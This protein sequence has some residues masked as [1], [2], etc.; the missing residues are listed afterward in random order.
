MGSRKKG[1]SKN[2]WFWICFFSGI[3]GLI[4]IA[5][6]PINSIK[7]CFNKPIYVS[8]NKEE[9]KP[10][11]EKCPHCGGYYDFAFRKCPHCGKEREISGVSHI[12]RED[13]IESYN[14]KCVKCNRILPID[15]NIKDSKQYVC[16]YCKNKITEKNVLFSE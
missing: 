4:A 9:V 16:P 1:Y 6:A 7:E 11:E 13:K 3:I 14:I 15:G 2:S 10:G 12:Q 5:G 8:S